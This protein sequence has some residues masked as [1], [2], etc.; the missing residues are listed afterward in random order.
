MEVD[1]DGIGAGQQRFRP[2]QSLCV[3]FWLAPIC[4]LFGSFGPYSV[5]NLSAYNIY[6]TGSGPLKR[7]A[8]CL[9]IAGCPALRCGAGEYSATKSTFTLPPDAVDGGREA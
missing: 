2:A 5:R 4:W 3:S 6:L 8:P 7:P 9:R 1:Y